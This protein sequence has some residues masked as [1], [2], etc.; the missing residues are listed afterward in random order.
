MEEENHIL[1]IC[2]TLTGRDFNQELN[3]NLKKELFGEN[4]I[5]TF[6][7][8]GMGLFPECPNT[9]QTYDFIWFA[10]CNIIQNLFFNFGHIN[11]VNHSKIMNY[12]IS[13]INK[14]NFYYINF[15]S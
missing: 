6:C 7:N 10:G 2:S 4:P 13:T 9:A 15:F 1:V 11:I 12:F 3:N 8:G 14:F 5:Y